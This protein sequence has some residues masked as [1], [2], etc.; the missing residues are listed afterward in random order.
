MIRHGNPL[1]FLVLIDFMT[2]ALARKQN[3]ACSKTLITSSAVT[4]L[5]TDYSSLIT[6][7]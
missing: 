5:I 2:P 1:A 6:D 3:P 4:L 7:Y